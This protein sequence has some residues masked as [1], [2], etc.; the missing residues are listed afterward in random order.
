MNHKKIK[1]MKL[2][3]LQGTKFNILKNL[4]NNKIKIIIDK[5]IIRIVIKIKITA[6]TVIIVNN[7]EIIIDK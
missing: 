6:K 4:W 5:I 7:I 1:K 3:L 2:K